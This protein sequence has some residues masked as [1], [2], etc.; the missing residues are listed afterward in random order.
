MNPARFDLQ[1]LAHEKD[2]IKLHLIQFRQMV[3]S[4]RE[5]FSNVNIV[6][7]RHLA[8]TVV[9]WSIFE[10]GYV[11]ATSLLIL[12]LYHFRPLLAMC[13]TSYPRGQVQLDVANAL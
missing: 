11:T 9:F 6:T 2:R 10:L 7:N 13:T 4:F 12:H 3:T 8:E 1:T 5:G